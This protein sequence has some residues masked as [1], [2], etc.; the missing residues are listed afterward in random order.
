MYAICA[1]LLKKGERYRRRGI[2]M[3]PK[4]LGMGECVIFRT[5]KMEFLDRTHYKLLFHQDHILSYI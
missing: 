3:E 5:M 4:W 1:L 2:K